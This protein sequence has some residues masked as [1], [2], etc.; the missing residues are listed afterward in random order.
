MHF[1]VGLCL[2]LA[3]L[4]FW[5][6]GHWFARVVMFLGLAVVVAFLGAAVVGNSATTPPPA[7][8]FRKADLSGANLIDADLLGAHLSRAHLS[9]AN[10]LTQAQ[11]DQA[12]GTKAKLLEGLTLR[13]CPADWWQ[14]R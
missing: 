11:L 1:L 8:D 13:P 4:Y 5:L 2:A 6:L 9:G 10:N 12:C 3:L 14:R 7:S